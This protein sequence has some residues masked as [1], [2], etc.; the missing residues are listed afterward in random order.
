[1]EVELITETE[2]Y[3]SPTG[4]ANLVNRVCPSMRPD[5]SPLVQQIITPF[6]KTPHTIREDTLKVENGLLNG[7]VTIEENALNMGG[8][9]SVVL[10]PQHSTDLFCVRIAQAPS[11]TADKNE[12]IPDGGG[13]I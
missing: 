4:G 2:T 7:D 8:L 6:V 1:L 5:P 12:Y 10:R 11:E 3:I 9:R 13:V